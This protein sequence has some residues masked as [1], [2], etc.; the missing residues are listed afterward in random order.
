MFR[1]FYYESK[2]A[3]NSPAYFIDN[4]TESIVHKETWKCS[5]FQKYAIPDYIDDTILE[6]TYDNLDVETIK[7]R[8]IK[9]VRR[10]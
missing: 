10:W 3:L 4:K 5:H 7:V 8:T 6:G 2:N 1:T 9:L